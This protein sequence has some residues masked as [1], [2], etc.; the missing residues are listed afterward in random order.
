MVAMLRSLE[1]R[2][3]PCAAGK[4][5]NAEMQVQKMIV[6]SDGLKF[7]KGVRVGRDWP[8]TSFRST[9]KCYLANLKF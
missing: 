3:K 7:N 2:Q 1:P 9:F 5:L 8:S 6:E 4:K